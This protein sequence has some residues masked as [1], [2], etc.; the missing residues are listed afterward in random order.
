MDSINNTIHVL[1]SYSY[2]DTNNETYT[3]H[4]ILRASDGY[5]MEIR[6][7][8]VT[9]DESTM[10]DGLYFIY[11]EKDELVQAVAFAPSGEDGEL[12]PYMYYEYVGAWAGTPYPTTTAIQLPT[13]DQPSLQ[14]RMDGH[15]YDMQGR[16]IRKVTDAKDPF[17]SLPRGF[18]IYQGKKYLKR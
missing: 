2:D 14:K 1:Y 13:K 16:V 8:K 11:N 12:Y 5:P 9:G 3:D 17:S 4:Y 6:T 7:E 18:Y 15:V 10:T